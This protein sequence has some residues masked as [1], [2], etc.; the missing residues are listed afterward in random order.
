MSAEQS[1]VAVR[2][3]RRALWRKSRKP[4]AIGAILGALFGSA[5]ALV[6]PAYGWMD[7]AASVPAFAFIGGYLGARLTWRRHGLQLDVLDDET[8][9]GAVAGGVIGLLGTIVW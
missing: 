9:F 8:V 3:A 7:Y 1:T 5:G 6:S 2:A 4:V